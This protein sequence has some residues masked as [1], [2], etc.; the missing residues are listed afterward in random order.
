MPLDRDIEARLQRWAQYVTV[1]DGSGYATIST[2]H[3]DWTPPSPGMTPA[4]KASTASDVRQTHRAIAQLSMRLRNT[5]V[6]HYCMRLP[7][8]EQAQR[9]DCS[10]S[11]VHARVFDAHGKL[12][13][14]LAGS[15]CNM[16]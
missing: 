12:R 10:R 4:L 11:T 5:L 14:I 1:G 6:V 15:F 13:E 9:L 3:E 8:E 7:V 2:L 16:D